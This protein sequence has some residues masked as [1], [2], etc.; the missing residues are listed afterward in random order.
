[1]TM[2]LPESQGDSGEP[3]QGPESVQRRAFPAHDKYKYT[4][5]PPGSMLPREDANVV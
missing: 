3:L 5:A 2:R 1:M 4:F